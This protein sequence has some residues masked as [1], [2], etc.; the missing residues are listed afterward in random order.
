MVSQATLKT[1]S[2]DWKS[3]PPS[4]SPQ[5]SNISFTQEDQV[6]LTPRES[7]LTLRTP[8]ALTL[9]AD[10]ADSGKSVL[11]YLKFRTLIVECPDLIDLD[12]L[13]GLPIQNLDLTKCQNF[14][15]ETPLT[16]P[17]LETITID[18]E[19]HSPK[20][21]H[22]WIRGIQNFKIIQTQKE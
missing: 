16:L 1:S 18:P 15:L 4:S 12:Q 11:R 9:I 7:K 14:T 21:L 10:P 5:P 8:K 20:K 13:N 19:K 17:S 3:L 22:K 2:S 6:E